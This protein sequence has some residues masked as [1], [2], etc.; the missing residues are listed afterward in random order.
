MLWPMALDVFEPHL[1]SLKVLC[2]WK[3]KNPVICCS[4]SCFDNGV[5]GMAKHNRVYAF[6]LRNFVLACFCLRARVAWLYASC[7]LQYTPE[8]EVRY[9]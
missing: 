7:Y 8:I 3:S 1:R 5:F 9:V 2:L 6:F 4:L